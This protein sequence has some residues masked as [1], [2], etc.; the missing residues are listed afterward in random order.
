MNSLPL[1]FY[2][3]KWEKNLFFLTSDKIINSKGIAGIH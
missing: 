3:G 1:S 2:S